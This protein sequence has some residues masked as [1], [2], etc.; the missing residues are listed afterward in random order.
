MIFLQIG[1]LILSGVMTQSSHFIQA[2][3]TS[4]NEVY[5]NMAFS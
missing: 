2:K 3:A 1:N 5:G 4:Q